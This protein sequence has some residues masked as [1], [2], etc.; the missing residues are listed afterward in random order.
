MSDGSD[1]SIG[2]SDIC[3][4]C[5]PSCFKAVLPV[6][7]CNYVIS[8]SVNYLS[9]REIACPMD[10]IDPWDHLTFPM[11]ANPLAS[12]LYNLA[13]C[14][15]IIYSS[16]IPFIFNRIR[17]FTI[18]KIF[19]QPQDSLSDG[20]DRSIGPSDICHACKPPC[21]KA[22]LLIALCNY[23]ISPSVN[24][25]SDRKIACAMDPIDPSDICHACKPF[26]VKTVLLIALCN[27]I[28]SP[29]VKYLSNRKIVCPMDPIDPSD[30]LTFPMLANPLAS[31]L[32]YLALC[33]LRHL[34]VINSL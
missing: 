17:Q 22:V 20:S 32:Y 11:L 21:F 28:I 10:P 26:C 29:S 30:H 5:K 18:S 25:L 7:L 34:L 3:H 4:A 14:N 8:P 23:V 16:L 24:Y 33:K 15:Y 2:P 12:R 9:D 1:R 6:A 13:L 19:V 27:Y 31:R